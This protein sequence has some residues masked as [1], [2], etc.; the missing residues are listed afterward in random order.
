[1]DFVGAA[2]KGYELRLEMWGETR[3]IMAVNKNGAG[4]VPCVGGTLREAIQSAKELLNNPYF[5]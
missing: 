3:A 4:V 1:M 2:E 5:K